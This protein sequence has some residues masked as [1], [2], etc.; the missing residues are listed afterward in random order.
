MN[1]LSGPVKGQPIMQD[2]SHSPPNA[3]SGMAPLARRYLQMARRHSWVT[4]GILVLAV[5]L[6]TLVTLLMTPMF[7]AAARIEVSRQTDN[8]TNVE[9]LEREEAGPSLEF[10]ATQYS[11]LDTRSLASRV[12]RRLRLA[13]SEEFFQAHGE[14]FEGLLSSNDS[15]P[16]AGVQRAREQ[17]AVELLLNNVTISPIRGSAL[18]DVMYTS[19]D[20]ELSAEIANT[21]VEE[22]AR[23]TQDRRYESTAEARRFLETRLADLR[24]RLEQSERD[25]V[26][27]ATEQN[28]VR[29]AES[30]SDDGRT[31]T[32]ETLAS[33]DLSALNSALAEATAARIAAQAQLAATR[34]NSA[35]S[36][37]VA[38]VALNQMRDRRAE[39][40]SEYA[41]LLVQFEPAYPAARAVAEQIKALDESI[42]REERRVTAS[43]NTAYEAAQR[44]EDQLRAQVNETLG[45]FTDENRA[46]IQYNIYQR[47]VDT[48]RELYDALLQRFKEIGVAGVGFSN[49]AIVDRADVPEEPSSPNLLLNIVLALLAGVV[50][51]VVVIAILENLDEGIR[52]PEALRSEIDEPILGVIPYMEGDGDDALDQLAD[53]KSTLSE[54][55]MTVRTN[56]AFSTANGV[57]RVLAVTSSQAAE[58]KS[59]TSLAIAKLLAR[60]QKRV[61]LIDLDMR[62]PMMDRM[63]GGPRDFGMS[64]YLSGSDEVDALLQ[65]TDIP[66]LSFVSAGPIPP[67]AAELLS[68]DRLGLLLTELSQRFDHIV[69]DS[70]P[71]LGLS[72]APLIGRAVDGVLFVVQANRTPVRSVRHAVDRIRAGKAH[73]LGVVLTKFRAEESDYG[74][75]YGYT[76]Q[77]GAERT[78]GK[79]PA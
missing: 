44:R 74:Y 37:S 50:V 47:E 6:A 73:I 40:A 61:V 16:T 45:E 23:Q 20:P 17:E 19:A 64:N 26:N 27:Y 9:T 71:V 62:R 28:I 5:V 51:V 75:G 79:T 25:L 15:I 43:I 8:V 53:P 67:S 66:N 33:S 34:Q 4:A 24:T 11:L 72:D 60:N 63:I 13:N 48:N 14:T 38:N 39:L 49:I 54:A 41:E 3:P 36:Q 58:G 22:F 2:E 57:P 42:L 1:A 12:A 29:L 76:Y 55:Y 77:Y 56:L 52:D 18:I 10:Y 68:S 31:R 46:S 30:R 35:N 32:T 78:A 65:P 59:T 70:S 21:W 7:T 69:I